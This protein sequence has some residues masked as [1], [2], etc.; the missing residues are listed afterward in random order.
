MMSFYDPP[1]GDLDHAIAADGGWA[2][3][4]IMKAGYLLTLTEPALLP[5]AAG[6]LQ[7]ARQL[8]AGSPERER[9]HL[10]A[11]DAVLQ[12]RWAD[13]CRLWDELLLSH[14]RDALAMQWAHL[15]DFHRGDSQA[16]RLRC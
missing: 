14:P 5:Q 1:M 9:V 15:W 16:L 13:A 7:D 4:H 8:I 11:V 12:G 10:E 3:P 2:L 6:H